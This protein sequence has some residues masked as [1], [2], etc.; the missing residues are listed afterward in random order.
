MQDGKE[1]DL[2]MNMM[3]NPTETPSTLMLG[4]LTAD[5]TQLLDKSTYENSAKVQDAFKDSEG[6]FDKSSFDKMYSNAQT[7][8]N[9]MS[10]DAYD[11]AVAKQTTYHRDNIFAPVEQRRT[12]PDYQYAIVGNPYRQSKNVIE[13]GKIGDRTKSI[14]ELAQANKVLL[15]PTSAGENLENAEWGDTPNGNFGEYFLDTLVLAQYDEDGTHKDP[16]TGQIVEHKKGDLRTDDKGDFY[17]EK[18]D[19]RDIYGRRVL[20]KMNVLTTDGSKWNQYDFFDSDDIDQKSI[21]GSVMKNLALVGSMF[22]PYVG[23]WI[24]GLSIATQLAGLGATFGKMLVGSDSPM[25]SEIEGWSKSVSRQGAQTEYA[26]EHTWCWENFINLIGDVAGQLKEQRYIFEKAP[27]LITG[28]NVTSEAKAKALQE[29][30]LKQKDEYLNTQIQNL[31]KTDPKKLFAGIAELRLMATKDAQRQVEAIIARNQKLGAVLSKGYMTAVTVGDTYGEAKQAGA[32]DLDATLLTL[33]Y[34]AGEYALLSTGLGEWILPEL[35]AGRYKAKAIVNALAGLNKETQALQQQFSSTL[36]NLPKEGKKQYVKKLFNIGKNIARAEY[37]NGV[38]SITSTLAAGAGEGVEETSEELLADF[39]KSCYNTVKWLQGDDT[40]INAFGYDYSTSTFNPDEIIDRYGMSLVGG[41]IGGSLTNLGTN[42]KAVKNLSDM[43]SEQAMQEM[44]YMGRNGQLDNFLKE[45]D[46]MQVGDKNLSTNYDQDERTGVIT[47]KAGTS[48][49]NQD[50]F[51]K[52]AIKAQ[53][54]IIKQI[55]DANGANLSDDSFLDKQTLNDLRLAALHK[56]TMAGDYLNQ[57]N[58]L[59]SQVVKLTSDINNLYN[60]FYDSNKDGTVS[61]PEKR[62][63]VNLTQEQ[64][65]QVKK[66]EDQL[67]ETKQQLDDLTS[68]KRAYEFVSNALFEMTPTLGLETVTFPM[69]AESLYK[70]RFSELTDDDK[71]KA[72]EAYKIWKVSDG[73]DK[74]RESAEIFRTVNENASELLKTQEKTYREVPQAL[75]DITLTMANLYN[76]ESTTNDVERWLEEAQAKVI[77][78]VNNLSAYLIQNLGSEQEKEETQQLYQKLRNLLD[79][80]DPNLTK[81]E[82][83][84]KAKE[85]A[86]EYITRLKEIS[87]DNIEKFVEPFIQQGFANHEVRNQLKELLV[88]TYNNLK[89]EEGKFNYAAEEGIYPWDAV[90]PYTQRLIKV[91][92]LME[93]VDSLKGT[94]VETFMNEF[95][96]VT[97]GEP[98]NLEELRN[99]VSRTLKDFKEDVTQ[100]AIEDQLAE[101]L[102]N[103]IQVARMYRAAILAART[104][105]VNADNLYGYNATLNEVASKIEGGKSP[106]LAEINSATADIF[107]A[108]VDYIIKDLTFLR[109]L[110]TINQNQKLSRQDRVAT[111]KDLL[112][113]KQLKNIVTVPDDDDLKKWDGYLE[114]QATLE[115]ATLHQNLLSNN[116]TNIRE[117][118]KVAYQK[119][120]LDIEEAVYNFFQKNQSKLSNP[121]LLKQFINPKR[122]QLYTKGEELLNEGLEN[123]DDN[124][125][126]WWLA[127][128]AA[129]NPK[130]FY[131]NYRKLV[132]PQADNPL[133]PIATQELA[134]YTNY[135]SVVNGSVFTQFYN[136]YRESVLDDWKSK[137]RQEREQILSRLHKDKELADDRLADYALNFLTV[138]RY[139]NIFLTEGIP[140]SGKTAAVF[141]LTAKLLQQTR[142]ELL[143]NVFIAHGA[144]PDSAKELQR[145]TGIEKA[146]TFSRE[147]LMR[148]TSPDWKEY[149]Y[150]PATKKYTVPSS[151]YTFNEDKEIVSSLGIKDTPNPPSLIIIDEV[152]KFSAYDMDLIDKYA[153]KY[154]ITVLVAGDFDQSGV[155]GEHSIKFDGIQGEAKWQVGLE[156]T[157]FMRTPKLGVSMRTD[158]SLKTASLQTMQATIQYYRKEGKLPEKIQFDYYQDETGFYGDEVMLYQSEIARSENED[159]ST[160]PINYDSSFFDKESVLQ[161]VLKRVDTMISTLKEGQKIGYIFSDRTSP[162]FK[163]LSS[164]K[165]SKYIDLKEGGSAQG[166]E[167]QYYVIEADLNDDI[168]TYLRD[169]YTGMSRAQQGSVIIAPEAKGDKANIPLDSREVN[170]KVNEAISNIAISRFAAKRRELL[171]AIAGEDLQVPYIPR[172]KETSIKAPVQES[173]KGL[174]AGVQNP[175]VATQETPSTTEEPQQSAESEIKEK[176][177]EQ[178]NAPLPDPEDNTDVAPPAIYEND[179][180]PVVTTDVISDKDYEE[181]V[182]NSTEGQELPQASALDSNSKD[183]NIPIS[184]TLYSF[185]T[186]EMGVLEDEN[187]MPYLPDQ[188]NKEGKL[189]TGQEWMDE[190]IDSAC[191]LIKIDKLHNH[192]TRKFLEYQQIIGDLRSLIFNTKDKSELCEKL[193]NILGLSNIYCT[194]AYKSSANLRENF[195]GEYIDG[196]PQRFTKSKSEQTYFN[197]SSDTRSH[198]LNRKS[199]VLIIGNNENGDLLELP[200]LTLSSP[201]TLLQIQN[202]D[203]TM[204]F[205]EVYKKFKSYKD[206]GMSYHDISVQL[207]QDFAGNSKYRDLMNLFKLYDFTDN[208][209][210]YIRDNQWTVANGL[211]LLGQSFI[212]NRG[213]VQGMPGMQFDE[214]SKPESEWTSV[215]DFA[216]NPRT[217]DPSTYTS[218]K[219]M[220]SLTGMVDGQD[221]SIQVVNAG[222]SFILRSGDRSLNSDEKLVDYYI[223]QCIDSSLEK[224]VKLI[225]VI[226]PKATIREYL[227]NIHKIVTQQPGVQPIGQVITSYR[228][229]QVL[230]NDSNFVSLMDKKSPGL[231]QKVREAMQ[232]L[233]ALPVQDKLDLLYTSQN[234]AEQGVSS[235]PI[236]LTGLL[237]GALVAVAYNK[238][239]LNSLI[240]QQNYSTL[241]EEAV[242][243]IESALGAQGLD[244]VY[245]NV[246]IPRTNP[247]MV[248]QF[249]VPSQGDNYT[250]AGR[251]FKVHGKVDTYTFKGNMSWL[252]DYALSNIYLNKSNHL[253]SRDNAKYNYE[254]NSNLDQRITPEQRIINNT[255]TYLRNKTGQDF[256]Q[257]YTDYSAYEANKKVVDAIN[258]SDNGQI[259]F[260]INGQIKVSNKNDF[261]K[262][263]SSIWDVNGN[264]VQDISNQVD[265]NG[266]YIFKLINTDQNGQITSYD[267][268]YNSVTQ[269]LE[270]TL[271]IE[272]APQT[273]IS[274]T[275][276]NFSDYRTRGSALFEEM[277]RYDPDLEN[278]FKNQ[279]FNTFSEAMQNL[280]FGGEKTEEGSR[281]G[282]LKRLY[283]NTEDETDKRI[284]EDFINLEE[285]HNPFKDSSENQ[286][287][288]PTT[289]K[290]NF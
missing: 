105:A 202:G 67:K 156:R 187:G 207:Q 152:S 178:E 82:N 260:I 172:N 128:R 208:G 146:Q 34:A 277:F 35:R 114:F 123:L 124:S 176:K 218:S 126:V 185:N 57:F 107:V 36:K 169:V 94:P 165:Y 275:Q 237:D 61:D 53:A 195:Q 109:D 29:K 43:T 52:N 244:G 149:Q 224:K 144:N 42:F 87:T 78:D 137:T 210:F 168:E 164:D 196:S 223:R 227:D 66:L 153:K 141:K 116:S 217:S 10:Q 167:A 171:D 228:L 283:Q 233:D 39:S 103:A 206:S 216:K 181:Q 115:G 232:Q 193:Q 150:N 267:A 80:P 253:A 284:I 252:V 93:K 129:V 159:G 135:A 157:N 177:T 62:Q 148:E 75:K 44:V 121:A 200:L 158:N 26:Q 41:A 205:N 55:L 225:Y 102:N 22:I 281:I 24:A 54:N 231:S 266:V 236:K 213:R 145:S 248:G 127:S 96:M 161:N 32:S 219:V 50:L 92:S 188:V 60:S 11:K 81:E 201:F 37:S 104:D 89:I 97:R 229:L 117:E 14:D 274:L 64:K 271:P 136:A 215:Y 198:E 265:N 65:D 58:T 247:Q 33:G 119:E 280:E 27:G 23:P 194:F 240:N 241:D 287:T 79:N 99:R 155:V 183:P 230:M 139:Q 51:I 184:M 56:S 273:A 276:Q 175:V 166:L 286:N 251:P 259:A 134:V 163:E 69:F 250:I 142:P 17:Y 38:K 174:Q 211:Q 140:G 289:I 258:N 269:Q 209:I 255:L 162:I 45:V 84:A 170:S 120:N 90:N 173:K 180:S 256:S 212:K 242:Q 279:D 15:N 204:V 71:A 47:F 272:Q 257:L 189:I 112:I 98:M 133:A 245:F 143:S 16:I 70:K 130:A 197:G 25:L 110:F 131:S 222:H 100:F 221:S 160:G 261:L 111:K 282:D 7:F 239:T 91:K 3:R 125:I 101:D 203:G 30:L 179:I 12:G 2:F 108:D 192:P 234:W 21:G 85:A 86:A 113:F 132:D 220:M 76:F 46:K 226:P 214:D 154:G 18:L 186:N 20:N 138:P 190:R 235:K 40:R 63:K 9:I 199:I 1:F 5:N 118:D 73:R 285:A 243:V 95:S 83:D 122:L 270:I 290:I 254:R 278:V 72:Y 6:N 288:C 106:E 191:G 8:Y 246:R 238:N 19:G 74:I 262:G 31:A 268:E 147:E 48:S 249:Y 88:Q 13:L 263:Q 182:D 4:G 264:P 49:D 151:D 77:S 68:G 28:K 59:S